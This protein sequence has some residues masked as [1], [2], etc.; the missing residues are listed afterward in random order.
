MILDEQRLRPE[1]SEVDRLLGSNSKLNSLIGWSPEY[2]FEKGLDETISW[3]KKSSNLKLYK[4]DIYN[5]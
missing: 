3:F 1:N 4:P 2:S 5:V